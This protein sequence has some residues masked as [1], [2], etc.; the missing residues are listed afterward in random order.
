MI[1]KHKAIITIVAV[2]Q[3]GRRSFLM[4]VTLNSEAHSCGFSLSPS[5]VVGPVMSPANKARG[6]IVGRKRRALA[7]QKETTNNMLP[8]SKVIERL[9]DE[10]A[11]PRCKDDSTMRVRTEDVAIAKVLDEQFLAKKLHGQNLTLHLLE[12]RSASGLA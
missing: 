8:T 10:V 5:H 7:T 3:N 12:A 6:S 9:K 2:G 11:A 4:S 1:A